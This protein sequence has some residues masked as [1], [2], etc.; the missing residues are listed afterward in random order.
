MSS[1]ADAPS[2]PSLVARGITFAP[3]GTYVLEGVDLT[4]EGG[5]RVALLGNNGAGKSTLLAALAGVLAGAGG[6][7]IYGSRA[8]TDMTLDERVRAFS[9]LPQALWRDEHFT[10]RGFLALGADEARA[11]PQSQHL[12]AFG[13]EGLLDASLERL[14]GGQ[15]RRVQLAKA[16]APGA[17]V[18]LLDEPSAGLDLRHMAALRVALE[19]ATED[20]CA[21]VLFSTHDLAFAAAAATHVLVLDEGRGVFFDTLERFCASGAAQRLFGLPVEWQSWGKRFIPKVHF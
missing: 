18:L 6:E 16:F 8:L 17:S 10:V 15:W 21:S 13:V 19:G 1:S 5:W 20:G 2:S 4:L 3:R 7:V 12:S 11:T 9:W 14:S